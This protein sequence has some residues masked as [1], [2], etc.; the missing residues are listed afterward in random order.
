MKAGRLRVGVIGAGRVGP[1]LGMALAGAGHEIVAISAVGDAERERLDVLLPRVPVLAVDDVVKRS[2][3]VIFAVPSKELPGLVQGLTD[4]DT[5]QAGQ[6]VLHTSAEH[7]FGVFQPAMASG[8]IPIA[9]HPAMV[10][11]GTSLDLARMQEATIAVTAPTPVLPIAQALAVEMGA[12]PV[13]VAE[14]SRAAYADACDALST[15]TM[16]LAKQ[17]LTS[18]EELGLEHTRR[19]VGSLARAALDEALGAPVDPLD[20]EHLNNLGL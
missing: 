12:E 16:T 14:A 20:P 10:F 18:L 2:E 4:T 11:T 5:W 6:I 1:V 3:L 9:F 13:I 19:T 8:I 7:G 17:A 15:L